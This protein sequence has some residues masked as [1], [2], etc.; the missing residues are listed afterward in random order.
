MTFNW[1]QPDWPNFRYDLVDVEADLLRFAEN[2]GRVGGMLRVLPEESQTDTLVEF[3]IAE[4][5]K[6]SAIEGEALSRP[7][8]KSSVRHRLGLDDTPPIHLD[9]ASAGA[10]EL[11][12]MVRQEWNSPL[13]AAGL[14]GWHRALMAGSDRVLVGAWRT[15]VEPM[16]VVSGAV[17]KERLHFEA[18]PSAQVPSEMEQ[19]VKW[20]NASRAE[21]VA[22]PVRAA[23]AHLYFESIHPFEDG[24]GRLGRAVSEKALSQSLGRPANISLSR[25]IEANRRDYYDALERAQRSNEVTAWLNYFVPTV[26]AAQADAVR[27]VEFVL[28]QAKLFDRLRDQL[29]PRQSKAL[30]R[31]LVDGPDEFEGGMNARKYG[32][33]NH[34]SKA[35]AT[36]DLQRLVTLGA[37]RPIGAGRSA[38][39][40]VNL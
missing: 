32:S 25:T 24:N 33:L 30:R 29:N 4:A 6:S 23:L 35:T 19:F 17:G 39:Y 15:Q 8:V 12:V 13:T 20:F 11:M 40:E 1:Q 18:P 10:A 2:A 5:M 37:L 16:Q 14:K 3:M 28:A 26:V 36:R 21:L 31:M 27:V 38:R 34:V 9:R 7:D 22:G